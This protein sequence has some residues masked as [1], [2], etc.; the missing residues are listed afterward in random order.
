MTLT[1]CC[2]WSMVIWSVVVKDIQ[3]NYA[4]IPISVCLWLHSP[5][6]LAASS[7]SISSS[8]LPLPSG[9]DRGRGVSTVGTAAAAAAAMDA[10]DCVG[11]VEAAEDSSGFFLPSDGSAGKSVG[12]GTD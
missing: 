8:H 11:F 5:L 10:R 12:V 6:A 4:N 1:L 3:A 9:G 2:N 7:S